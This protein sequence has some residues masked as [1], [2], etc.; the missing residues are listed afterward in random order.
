MHYREVIARWFYVV[1]HLI[2][3]CIRLLLCENPRLQSFGQTL[4]LERKEGSN[5]VQIV[6]ITGY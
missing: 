1:R 6:E 5:Q 2:K 4:F 3:T